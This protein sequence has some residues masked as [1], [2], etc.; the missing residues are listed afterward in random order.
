MAAL[1]RYTV[2]ALL[3][4]AQ[5]ALGSS[6]GGVVCFG[7]GSHE[8][9]LAS[10]CSHASSHEGWPL[11]APA[12]PDG[13]DDECACI[14]V[15]TPVGRADEF[16]LGHDVLRQS[17]VLLLLPVPFATVAPEQQFRFV[18]ADHRAPGPAPGLRTTR[19]LI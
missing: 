9:G 2:V 5:V 3:V 12:E 17:A 16:R 4:L 1:L 18:A 7:G 13:H 15:P 8:S 10:S 14:D 19:L 6:A 11:A